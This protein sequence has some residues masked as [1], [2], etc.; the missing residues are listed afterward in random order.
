MPT[1]MSDEPHFRRAIRADELAPEKSVPLEMDGKPIL[2]C[3]SKGEFFAVAN[4]CSHADEKLECGLVR[5]GWVA[6]PM[7]GA[8]FDLATGNP[9]NPP[10]TEPIATYPVRVQD[11]WVEIDSGNV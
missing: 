8:R 6:C 10:A 4:L 7:H 11:G 3:H 5:R 1:D 2:L 9:I